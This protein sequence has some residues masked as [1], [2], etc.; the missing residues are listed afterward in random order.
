M[1][2]GIQTIAEERERQVT[3]EG[4][5]P[6]HDDNHQSGEL[7]DAAMAYAYAAGDQARGQSLEYL[8]SLVPACE[9][10]WPWE[11]QW[12]KPSD[13]P[14]RNL[15][16]AGA[17]IAAEIDRLN[18]LE[19]FV[20]STKEDVGKWIVA[21][22]EGEEQIVEL[23]WDERGFLMIPLG[24]GRQLPVGMVEKGSVWKRISK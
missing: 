5:E 19:P 18:R 13:D 22:P 12:W 23:E 11:D 9:V 2:T 1:K 16:K 24:E 15:A 7:A 14:R 6:S 4:W 3:E 10:R 21:D 20:P 8:K 17:L